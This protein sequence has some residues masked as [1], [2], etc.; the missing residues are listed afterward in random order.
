MYGYFV[1]RKASRDF[2]YTDLA[3]E[4]RRADTSLAGV[5]YTKEDCPVGVWEKLRISTKTGADS[6]GRP[7]GNYNTLNLSRMDM[8]DSAGIEDAQDEIAKEL[9]SMFDD[10]SIFPERI[11][12]AGLGNRRLPPDSIGTRCAEAVKPTM[13]IKDFDQKMF[14]SLNCAEIAVCTP[15]VAAVSGLDA[16]LILR[17][18]CDIIKPNA[19]I[20]I[21]ALASRSARRLGRTI[22]ICNTGI[23]PGSGI[24]NPRIAISEETMGVPVIAIGVP[25]IID[26]RL[27]CSNGDGCN[28]HPFEKEDEAMF[29]SPKEIDDIVNSAAKIIGEGINMAFGIFV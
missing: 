21:D 2:P 25:T 29:V 11:V 27:F 13:H 5:Y 16:A 20:A 1:E 12:V 4:R 15:G 3:L 26:S 28:N 19:I 24:G 8:L 14:E 22:Q 18:I 17:G 10:S 9:C 7:I 23:S 6:I